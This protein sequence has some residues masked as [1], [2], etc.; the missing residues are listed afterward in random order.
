MPSLHEILPV[1]PEIVNN[2]QILSP[3]AS[4]EVAETIA[5]TGTLKV[6]KA[7][8]SL[9]VMQT[10]EGQLFVSR[11]YSQHDVDEIDLKTGIAFMALIKEIKS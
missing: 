9:K 10:T 7:A 11:D 2:Y 6:L 5:L 3:E 4:A 1:A 8:S